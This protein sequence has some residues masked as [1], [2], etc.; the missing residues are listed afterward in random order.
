MAARNRF[1]CKTVLESI[2]ADLR[3]FSCSGFMDDEIFLELV[4]NL[5]AQYP[6]ADLDGIDKADGECLLVSFLSL[7]YTGS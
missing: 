3:C 2:S 7:C 1:F 4:N 6:D 5:N